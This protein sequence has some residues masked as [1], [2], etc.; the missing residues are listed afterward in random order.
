MSPEALAPV[1]QQFFSQLRVDAEHPFSRSALI[2]IRASINR[3]LRAPPFSRVINIIT[4][5]RFDL[6]NQALRKCE[7]A[8]KRELAVAIQLSDVKK[9]YKTRTLCNDDPVSLQLKVF[10]EINLQLG[11]M[12]KYKMRSLTR[13]SFVFK[14][15]SKN[16]RYATLA[17]TSADDTAP[18]MYEQPGDALCPYRSLQLYLEKM[19]PRCEFFFQKPNS[20]KHGRSWKNP[21]TRWYV[22]TSLGVNTLCCFM[23]KISEAA[24]LS[25]TYSNHSI[26]L[27]SLKALSSAGVSASDISSVFKCS[28][29]IVPDRKRNKTVTEK[30]REVMSKIL[31]VCGRKSTAVEEVAVETQSRGGAVL[32]ESSPRPAV[33]ARSLERNKEESVD[34]L[35]SE[36]PEPIPAGIQISNPANIPRPIPATITGP[37][38]AKVSR[39]I[40]APISSP[41]PA[42]IPGPRSATITGPRA[43]APGANTAQIL[44]PIPA[45]ISGPI[46]AHI[47]GSIP[48]NIPGPISARIPGPIPT[49]VPASLPSSA[50]KAIVLRPLQVDVALLNSRSVHSLRVNAAPADVLSQ[51][52]VLQT[53]NQP[54]TVI[55]VDVLRPEFANPSYNNY[56]QNPNTLYM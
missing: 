43:R 41:I 24:G 52:R 20:F 14:Q 12:N 3:H 23:A 15:D 30:R 32:S 10:F 22:G 9:I 42:T 36:P 6:A 47:S 1:L 44:S 2:S 4:D 26:K 40:P 8:Q 25:Q 45:Q 38:S 7:A 5:A 16:A 51:A 34:N 39:F 35:I 28:P 21:E 31:A 33:A 37:S 50:P 19:H 53:A 13:H 54:T 55:S 17:S 18:R 29:A 27:T 48:A 49:P 11:Y 56:Q 46:Q